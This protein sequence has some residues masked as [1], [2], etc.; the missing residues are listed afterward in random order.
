MVNGLNRVFPHK[1]VPLGVWL[2]PPCLLL[3]DAIFCPEIAT[4]LLP[5]REK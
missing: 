2:K 1:E 3:Y 4:T 5:V